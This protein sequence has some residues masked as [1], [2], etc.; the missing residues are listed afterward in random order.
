MRG[1]AGGGRRLRRGPRGKKPLAW[2][3]GAQALLVQAVGGR[4]PL[5]WS[6]GS[7]GLR[8]MWCFLRDPQ[9]AGTDWGGLSEAGGRHGLPPLG[10]VSGLHLRLRS[11][12]GSTTTK[13]RALQP[14]ITRC[15]CHPPG[16][17]PTLPLPLLNALGSFQTLDHCPFPRPYI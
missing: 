7:M 11:P 6:K 12:Q 2:V 1:L 4:A 9:A 17:T 15:C 5:M 8:A 14:S 13:K 10:P 3:T 16:N